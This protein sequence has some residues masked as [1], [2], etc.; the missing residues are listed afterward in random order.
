MLKCERIGSSGSDFDVIKVTYE[1]INAQ[2]HAY[3][4]R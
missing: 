1:G 2:R 4:A 3:L